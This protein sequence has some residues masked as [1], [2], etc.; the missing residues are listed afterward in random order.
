MLNINTNIKEP[1]LHESFGIYLSALL[2]RFHA[3]NSLSASTI[4]TDRDKE[5]FCLPA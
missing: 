3:P 2:I 5:Y 4:P 1:E